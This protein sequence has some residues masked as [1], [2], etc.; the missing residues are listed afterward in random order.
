[1]GFF[2]WILKWGKGFKFK[3]GRDSDGQLELAWE[4]KG[5]EG[6]DS[7]LEWRVDGKGKGVEARATR[8]L[9]LAR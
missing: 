2:L 8:S 6:L 5:L 4:R 9:R 7:R 3:L 1:L